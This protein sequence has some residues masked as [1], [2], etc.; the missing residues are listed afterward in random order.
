MDVVADAWRQRGGE[1]VAPRAATERTARRVHDAAYLQRI[2]ETAGSGGRA[3][4]RHLHRPR[5]PYDVAA[6]G[7]RRGGRRGRAGDGAPGTRAPSRWFGRPDTTPSATARWASASTT[8][9][10]SPR[11]TPVR[12]APAG[13]RSSTT[14]SIT[15]TARSTSSRTIRSVLYVSTHQSPFYPGHRRG[16]RDRPWAGAGFTVNIPLEVGRGRRGL[17]RGVRRR[18]R[19]GA[20]AVQARPAAGLGRLRRPRAR[21][22]RRHAADDRR[23]SRR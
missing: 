22:A 4:R 6:A 21:P 10:P 5:R 23:R 14:T 18:R 15:A 2:A 8:T 16:R 19:P 9:S 7:G 11:R 12:S 3:R 13:S 1:V 17:P 20:P